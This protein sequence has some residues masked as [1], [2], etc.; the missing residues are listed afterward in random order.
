MSLI[1][2]KIIDGKIQIE[3]DTKISGENVVRNNPVKGRLKTLILDHGLT[4]SYA[5]DV[6]LAEDAYN[7]FIE[8]AKSTVRWEEY[9]NYLNDHSKTKQVEFILAGYSKDPFILKIKNGQIDQSSTAWIG[10]LNAF[11]EFQEYFFTNNRKESP[12]DKFTNSFRKVVQNQLNPT[13]GEFHITTSSNLDDFIEDGKETP[14]FQYKLKSEIA[15][16]RSK[17]IEIKEKGEAVPLPSGN[18]IEGDFA[19]SY[20][21]NFTQTRSSLG[22]FFEYGKFGIFYCAGK[23]LNG[24]KYDAQNAQEFINLVFKETGCELRG[25]LALE[26]TFGFKFIAPEK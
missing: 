2:A 21:T 3:S 13:V 1:I 6:A 20:F 12:S 5:G 24:I 14:V 25:M 19:I 8:K 17:K 23:L 16:G 9:L 4:V 10:D 18:S 7:W 15:I 22:I 26:N 11:R